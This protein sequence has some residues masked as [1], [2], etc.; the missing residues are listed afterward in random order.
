MQPGRA[1]SGRGKPQ[2]RDGAADRADLAGLILRGK[3]HGGQHGP[4]IRQ[5]PKDGN[6]TGPLAG[7][8]AFDL[9]G[10]GHHA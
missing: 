5:A 8:R 6:G 1:G 9:C 10:G 7:A 2:P 4:V 3:L